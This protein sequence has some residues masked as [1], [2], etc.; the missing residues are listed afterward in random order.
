M[1][2][3]VMKMKQSIDEFDVEKDTEPIQFSATTAVRLRSI[4]PKSGGKRA[5]VWEMTAM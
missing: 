2:E 5:L 1:R 4:V 3:L